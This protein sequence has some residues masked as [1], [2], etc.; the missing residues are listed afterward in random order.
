V[1][2]PLRNSDSCWIGSDG[3]G[4]S[5]VDDTFVEE[6]GIWVLTKWLGGLGFER[7]VQMEVCVGTKFL[8]GGVKKPPSLR[9]T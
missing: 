3:G 1:G 4:N 9:C 7:D 6:V 5:I 2:V 8:D